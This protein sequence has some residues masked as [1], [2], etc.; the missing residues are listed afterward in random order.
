MFPSVSVAQ[1]SVIKDTLQFIIIASLAADSQQT[2]DRVPEMMSVSMPRSCKRAC[3]SE[4]PGTKATLHEDQILLRHVQL[5]PERVAEIVGRECFDRAR[6]MFGRPA[7]MFKKDRPGAD[8]L[9][10]HVC[11]V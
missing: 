6:A 9:R 1:A 8:R 4:E 2:C 3:R 5:R 10:I 11:G 7:E